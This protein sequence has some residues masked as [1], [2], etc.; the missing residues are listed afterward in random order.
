M[1]VEKEIKYDVLDSVWGFV[2]DPL[3]VS[4]NSSTSSSVWN[5]VSG[6]AYDYMRDS[7]WHSVR[8]IV[9]NRINDYEY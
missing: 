2:L 7:L 8:R 4:V 9:D 1:S 3:Y 5:S 6:S